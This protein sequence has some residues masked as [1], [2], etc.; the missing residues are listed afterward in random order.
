METTNIER[1]NKNNKISRIISI[2]IISIVLVPL[3][4]T[5]LIYSTNKNFKNNTNKMLS[6]MPGM[7][8]EHFS[9]YPTEV[10]KD[11]KINYLSKHYIDLDP[12][13]AADKMYIIKKDDEKLYI[14]I[15]KEMNNISNS[16]TEEI[17]LKVRNMELRKDLLFSIYEEAQEE[18]KEQF[19]LEVNRIERQDILTSLLEI[20]KKFSDREF[21]KVL[22][23]VK[24]DKLGEILYYVDSDISAYITNTFKE[25]KKTSI[26]GVINEKTNE[27]NTLIDVAKV[28]ETKPLDMSIETIGNTEAYSLD[29]LGTIY[30]NLSILKSAE[31]LSNIK[32]EKF[33]EDLFA[34]IIR[35][36]Q[37]TKSETN[38]TSDISKTMEFLNEYSNKVNN[39]VMIYEK[40]APDKIAKIVE[41]MMQNTNT[42]T[43]I[44]INSENI[45]ELSDRTIIVDVLSK[46]KNQT[47]SKVFDYME[48]DKAS[49]ITR[50]LARPKD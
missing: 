42:I 39:L 41:K 6:K 20:E 46:M 49:Q 15:L 9:N 18:E 19:Q 31:L 37:L 28:Y 1:G 30:R 16:K 45:Y 21:L 22:S 29:K 43:S 24:T 23:E 10:E 35:E 36:E 50:L 38:I 8:G 5:I 33:I 26:E 2:V 32:D 17:V 13:V 48:P 27:I 44:E 40:M 34:A 25:S 3:G 12:S 14:D 11:E 4:I 47:L 7:I